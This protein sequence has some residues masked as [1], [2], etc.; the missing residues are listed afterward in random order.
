MSEQDKQELRAALIQ[1]AKTLETE[2]ACVLRI[3]RVLEKQMGIQA[4][5]VTVSQ[6]DSVTFTKTVV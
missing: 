4:E 2:R 5:P 3:T 1:L 6:G